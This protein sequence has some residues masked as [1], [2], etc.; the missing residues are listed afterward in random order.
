MNGCVSSL[1]WL[2]KALFQERLFSIYYSYLV[3]V[4]RHQEKC[5][6]KW[7]YSTSRACMNE[8][9]GFKRRKGKGKVSSTEGVLISLYLTRNQPL[10]HEHTF[11]G[12]RWTARFLPCV[13]DL[14]LSSEYICDC[15]LCTNSEVYS[16]PP[17][18]FAG[19]RKLLKHKK[20]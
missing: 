10:L 18:S 16:S 15:S 20:K 1:L 6:S 17:V 5:L 9:A 13:S 3:D 19:M 12:Y 4:Q 11:T 14:R 7:I 8:L 2:M